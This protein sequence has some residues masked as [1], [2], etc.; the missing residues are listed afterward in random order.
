MAAEKA[1]VDAAGLGEIQAQIDKWKAAEAAAA[2]A[3]LEIGRVVGRIRD[4]KL[5]PLVEMEKFVLAEMGISR[6]AFY[7]IV[8]PK[9]QEP[10]GGQ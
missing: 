2:E 7:R 8:P 4:A 3:K 6:A 10:E 5:L 9:A 1:A